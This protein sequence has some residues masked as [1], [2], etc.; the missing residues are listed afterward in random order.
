MDMQLYL[1]VVESLFLFWT[2]IALK[3]LLACWRCN[4]L[5]IPLKVVLCSFLSFLPL[6]TIKQLKSLRIWGILEWL[7]SLNPLKPLLACL[8]AQALYYL[9]WSI[10]YWIHLI[11]VSWSIIYQSA[12][13]LLFNSFIFEIFDETRDI[14][15][16]AAEYQLADMKPIPSYAA[17]YHGY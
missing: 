7:L 1:V 11:I 10:I 12:I 6:W 2:I 4:Y 5:Y 14:W 15:Y 13:I 17:E 9:Y 16:S 8:R 3:P